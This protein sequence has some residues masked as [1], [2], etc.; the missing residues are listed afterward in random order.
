MKVL[1]LGSLNIDYV[2]NLDHIVQPGET[3]SSSGMEVF[4]GGKGLNQSIALARAGVPV[5]HAGLIGEEGE[6]FIDLCKQDRIDISLIERIDGRNGH[7]IIQVDRDGQNCIFLYGG[8]NQK[9]TESYVDRVLKQFQS[10]DI[11]LLQNE[12]SCMDYII[13]SAFLKG[14]IIVLNPS[15]L[16]DQLQ[17]CDLSKVT[18]F[19]LNEIEGQAITGE[20]EAQQILLEMKI[21]FPGSGIV[22]TLGEKG[23]IYADSGQQVQQD[24]FP[25]EV[26]DT[27]AAG[28]TF[29]G[30]FLYGLIKGL[31]MQESLRLGAMAS[32]IAVSRKGAVPSIP[33]M[34]EIIK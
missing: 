22:L 32:S 25:V 26:V 20:K 10:G 31:S 27:T 1:N 2:Y 29:T 17:S 19:I 3:I 14:M 15:P 23:S 11:I 9:I 18:Y 6:I 8:S 4:C 28:D 7:S 12:I 5:Y 30:Y 34:E 16:N 21:Q 33:Y 24:V 13:E